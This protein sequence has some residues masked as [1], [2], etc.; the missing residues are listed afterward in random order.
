LL[1]LT[2]PFLL[3]KLNE[4]PSSSGD[5]HVILVRYESVK[6]GNRIMLFETGETFEALAPH[7]TLEQ[8]PV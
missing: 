2:C 5:G 8:A 3:L 1:A 6:R 7:G 4:G